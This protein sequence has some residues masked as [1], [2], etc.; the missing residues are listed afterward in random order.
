MVSPRAGRTTNTDVNTTQTTRKIIT[1]TRP[2]NLELGSSIG[3]GEQPFNL[4]VDCCSMR[5]LAR[6]P[7]FLAITLPRSAHPNHE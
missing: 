2:L 5:D 4:R 3:N 7:L 6:P 1:D